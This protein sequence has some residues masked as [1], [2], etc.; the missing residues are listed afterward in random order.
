VNTPVLNLA[1]AEGRRFVRNPLFWL[2]SLTIVYFVRNA[3]NATEAEASWFVLTGFSLLLP[4]FILV[5]A[6]VLAVLR[7]R[8]SHTEELLGTCAVGPDRRSIAHSVSALWCAALGAIAIAI[9]VVVLR[10]GSNLGRWSPW[11]EDPITMPFPNLALLLQGPMALLAV[12]AFI[13]ALVR[14]VPTWLVI[15]PMA[16]LLL[17]QASFAGLFHGIPADG[18][19]WLY[20][21]N[22]GIVNGE[23]V[24]GCTPT[25][26]CELEV[27]GFDMGTAWWHLAY[28]ASLTVFCT[29]V[30]VLRH[31]RDR[32]AWIAFAVSA[33]FVMATAAAQ[34]LTATTYTSR[35]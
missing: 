34:V 2:A 20:P 19:R 26:P 7:G 18:A 6:M 5:M 24:G 35:T 29:V 4:G 10:E 31:R 13:V 22:S 9:A 33:V 15:V 12:L 25:S 1:V 16:F 21:L 23:W 27:A 11:F 8:Y 28:L 17:V 14:W 32:S 3:A 30:A